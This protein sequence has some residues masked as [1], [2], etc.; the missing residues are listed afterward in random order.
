MDTRT[1]LIMAATEFDRKQSV[2]PGH[3]P[4]ALPQYFRAIDRIVE[5]IEAGDDTRTAILRGSNGRFATVLLRSVG[6]RA[7]TV[8]EARRR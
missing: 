5:D 4:Y 1:K 3:N 8:E 6:E 7:I 2:K